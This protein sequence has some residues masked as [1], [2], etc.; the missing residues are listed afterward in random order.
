MLLSAVIGLVLPAAAFAQT[1]PPG[2][3]NGEMSLHG[4]YTLTPDSGPAGSTVALNGSFPLFTGI[5]DATQ[6]MGPPLEAWWFT[7]PGDATFLGELPTD[8]NEV[9]TAYVSG[10]ITIPAGAAPGPHNVA[11]DIAGGTDPDCVVFT[12]TEP[13]QADAYPQ[14]GA[15]RLPDTGYAPLLPLAGAAAAGA[16][17]TAWRRRS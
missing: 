13:V 5:Q 8:F 9:D 12:V 17:L 15:N 10:N 1:P 14:T 6:I 16:L 7:G 11:L 4:T 2:E 3:C